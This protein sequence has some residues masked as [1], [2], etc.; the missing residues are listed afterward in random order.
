MGPRK[1]G[2]PSWLWLTMP[3]CLVWAWFLP[4][5]KGS[6]GAETKIQG[7]N[8][9]TRVRKPPPLTE[10]PKGKNKKTKKKYQCTAHMSTYLMTLGIRQCKSI[11]EVFAARHWRMRS[12]VRLLVGRGG[13]RCEWLYTMTLT[14]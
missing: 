12:Q 4:R 13:L 3:G 2:H 5:V 1:P 11:D 9:E 7:F 10:N 8:T 14:N 6:L